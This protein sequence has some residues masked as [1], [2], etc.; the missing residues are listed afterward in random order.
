MFGDGVSR[1]RGYRIV[2]SSASLLSQRAR[3]SR[4]SGASKKVDGPN[5]VLLVP[6]IEEM[7]R[8]DLRIQVFEIPS[9]DLISR[10]NVSMKVDAVLYFD[11]VNPEH[12]IINAGRFMLATN[13]L[14]QTTLRAVVGQHDPDEMLSEST[15]TIANVSSCIWARTARAS[16]SS[17]DDP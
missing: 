9:Q 17:R 15:R 3:G 16:A 11:V 5:L 8:V 10:D 2:Q 13:M 14:A 1:V 6:Y 7:V 12:A 4:R